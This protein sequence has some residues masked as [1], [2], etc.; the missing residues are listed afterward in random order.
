MFMYIENSTHIRGSKMLYFLFSSKADSTSS[1]IRD[2]QSFSK[3]GHII[4][5]LDLGGHLVSVATIDTTLLL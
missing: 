1:S 5:I 2:W 4:N 3:K